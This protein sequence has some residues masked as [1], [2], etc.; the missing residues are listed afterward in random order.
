[1]ERAV[2]DEIQRVFSLQQKHSRA[3]GILS[4]EARAA[5]RRKLRHIILV[6]KA[7]DPTSDL[8]GL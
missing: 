4:Y 8:S 2:Y 1:M 3:M 5:N 6:N 7:A